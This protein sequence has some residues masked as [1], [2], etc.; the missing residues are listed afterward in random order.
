M[1]LSESQ[2][3]V[4]IVRRF[5]VGDLEDALVYADPDI[6]WNPIEEEASQGPDAVRA[7]MARWMG[8]WDE[9][10]QVVEELID[11]GDRVFGTFSLRGRGRGSGIEIDQRLYSV[12]TLRD[13]KVA[14]MDEYATRA[15]ALEAAGLSE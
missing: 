11:L 9:Y 6:V 8:E 14:R 4:E 12:Y 5:V 2:E 13:G 3:N 1:E 7:S 15:E 10:E